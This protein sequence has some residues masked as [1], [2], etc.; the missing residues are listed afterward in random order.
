[1]DSLNWK[2]LKSAI[3]CWFFSTYYAYN[4]S[5]WEWNPSIYKKLSCH[6]YMSFVH[7]LRSAYI[8]FIYY[9]RKSVCYAKDQIQNCSMSD[10]SSLNNLHPHRRTKTLII[11]WKIAFIN[12]K[13]SHKTRIMWA[14]LP[15]D[16][17]VFSSHNLCLYHYS[18]GLNKMPTTVTF[19][20]LFALTVS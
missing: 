4:V 3:N 18:S 7:D 20:H 9:Y 16:A 11:L 2:Q 12:F 17:T 5:S 19:L 13:I 8:I 14:Q 15:M 1:M 6:A 10:N